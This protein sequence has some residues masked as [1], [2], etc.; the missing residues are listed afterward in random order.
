MATGGSGDVLTGILTALICQGLKIRDAAHLAAHVHGLAAEKAQE[1]L[2]Y[3][4]V[5]PTELIAS[6]PA[7][8]AQLSND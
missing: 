3:H 1:R 4:V 6:L 2:G 5:L 7:A 8:F